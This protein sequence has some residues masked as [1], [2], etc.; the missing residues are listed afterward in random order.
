VYFFRD[1]VQKSLNEGGLKFTDR[2]KP[3][4]QVDVD[5][6]KDVDAM[7]TE[8][9]NCN[10]VEAIIDVVEKLYVEAKVNV[11]ECQVVEATEGPKS[12]DEV[13]YKSQFAEKMKMAYL[14]AEE[15]LIDFLNHCRLKNS[16][17]MLCLRCNSVFDKETTKGLEGF[18]P[19]S[20][21]RGKWSAN[22]RLKVS[23]TNS[24]IPF[25]GN[26]STTNYVNKNGQ[27]KTFLPHAKEPVQKWVHSTHK[28]VQNRKNNLMKDSTIIAITKNVAT[29]DTEIPNESKK[30]SYSNNCKGENPI[31]MT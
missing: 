15:E 19:K 5:P 3:Q 28:N 16:E 24:Y 7:Y 8:V 6:L 26:S 4:M 1:L 25:I 14:M 2:P 27:E 23:F 18:I 31:T 12:A 10:V 29:T 9:I 11:V 30:Y 22:H 20:K 21:K 13:I 17:V